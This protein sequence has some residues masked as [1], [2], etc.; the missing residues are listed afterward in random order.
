[1]CQ[2]GGSALLI[3]YRAVSTRST[4]QRLTKSRKPL[5]DLAL[6]GV[7]VGPNAREAEHRRA[8]RALPSMHRNRARKVCRQPQRATAHGAISDSVD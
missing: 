6:Q 8:A 4:A 5:A 7:A 3:A 1:M 2:S